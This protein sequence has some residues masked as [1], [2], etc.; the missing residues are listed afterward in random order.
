MILDWVFLGVA[1]SALAVCVIIVMRKF[2]HLRILDVESARKHIQER[3]KFSIIEERLRRK[4]KNTTL[5]LA[6]SVSPTRSKITTAWHR[7]HE[8]VKHLEQRYTK[9]AKEVTPEQREKSRQ[10]VDKLLEAGKEFVV[11]NNLVEAERSFIEAISLDHQNQDAYKNLAEVYVL[12]K[13]WE[14]AKESLEFLLKLDPK[15]AQLHLKLSAVCKQLDQMKE[16][17]EHAKTAVELSPN[18]PKHLNELLEFCFT[19]GQKYTAKKTFEKLKKVNPENQ[20]IPEWEEK[21][22]K[23]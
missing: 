22:Q 12:Q 21:L 3:I 20:R 8:K 4:L 18:D 9:D 10:K 15:N 14:H 6:Q 23:M 19:F 13:N 2:P 11:K 16:A 5:R 17:F 7:L 1:I